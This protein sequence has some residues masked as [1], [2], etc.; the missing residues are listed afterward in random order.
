MNSYWSITSRQQ[1]FKTLAS[2]HTHH[3]Q[4]TSETP[5]GEETVSQSLSCVRLFVTPWSVHGI[6]RERSF[7]D[8]SQYPAEHSTSTSLLAGADAVIE[9]CAFQALLDIPTKRASAH[10]PTALLVLLRDRYFPSPFFQPPSFTESQRAGK[11]TTTWEFLHG[12]VVKSLPSNTGIKGSIPDQ[13]T[14]IPHATEQ[15]SP[16]VA[17]TEARPLQLEKPTGHSKVPAQPKKKK[18]PPTTAYGDK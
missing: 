11:T 17:T 16:C 2:C 4:V 7:H 18:K 8:K 3:A 9:A 13:E 14:N 6:L 12:P 1:D 5:P 15:L 10:R